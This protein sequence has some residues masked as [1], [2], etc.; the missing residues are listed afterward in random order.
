[1]CV[2]ACVH[3]CVQSVR[4]S[5][6]VC[7][8]LCECVRVN[9]GISFV[10]NFALMESVFELTEGFQLGAK[11]V[12]KRILPLQPYIFLRILKYEFGNAT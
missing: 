3:V 7:A 12:W 6:Y 1:M 9:G 2:R 8:H 10:F 11:E 4:V 5:Q